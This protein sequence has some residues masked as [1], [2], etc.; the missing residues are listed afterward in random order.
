MQPTRR[1]WELVGVAVALALSAVLFDR[2]V[3]LGGAAVLF[4]WLLATQVAF[5]SALGELDASLTV[6]QSLPQTTAI[7]EP[8]PYTLS[9]DGETYG[10]DVT[11]SAR[12]SV[13]LEMDGTGTAPLGEPLVTAVRSP[14]AG[15][16]TLEAPAITITDSRGVFRERL[17]RGTAREITVQPREPKRVHVGEG[18]ES[19]PIAFG[20]H[21]VDTGESGLIPAG[22]RE[23]TAGESISRMDWKATARLGTPH[24]REFESES[25]ITTVL[26]VDRR[27]RLD[28]G[29]PGE[30]AF[31]YLRS[32]ALSYLAVV[33]SLGDPVGCFTVDDEHVEQLVVPTNSARGYDSVRR[34]LQTASAAT[35]AE[36]QRRRVSLNH[37]SPMLGT[38]TTFGRTL[39]SY[40]NA[41]ATTPNRDPLSTA[42]KRATNAQQGTVQLAVFTD[43][44]D[45]AEL[46]NAVAETKRANVRLSV[47]IA[48]QSLYETGAGLGE[49]AIGERYR[50]FER[51]RRQLAAIDGVTAYEVAPRDRIERVLERSA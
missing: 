31:E 28:T 46:R 5:V 10:L 39:A 22:L 15:T 45:H 14:L 27:G 7:D 36:K 9:V 6:E 51:F 2:P 24:I 17:T 23:Y 3:L 48:P 1:Y 29:P 4:G 33:E 26:V 20:E 18:G 35:A 38:E 30:T 11:V 21:P 34:R 37:R 12:P 49:R 42:V 19:I 44:S 32:S 50:E 16:H 25:E 43:D 41:A 40:T 13:G 8:L 47:F